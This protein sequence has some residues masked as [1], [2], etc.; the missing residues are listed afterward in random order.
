MYYFSINYELQLFF[1]LACS[2]AFLMFYDISQNVILSHILSEILT[3]YEVLSLSGYI[4]RPKKST[5]S[6]YYIFG[7]PPKD[8]FLLWL[9]SNGTFWPKLA[10]CFT[11]GPR[12]L[13]EEAVCCTCRRTRNYLPMCLYDKTHNLARSTQIPWIHIS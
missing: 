8:S 3:F 4:M 10:L 1:Y 6:C 9:Y 13:F 5:W 7:K 12:M 11:V 2:H